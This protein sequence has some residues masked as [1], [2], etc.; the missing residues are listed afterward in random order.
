MTY[1]ILKLMIKIKFANLI[2]IIL[3]KEVIPELLQYQ[4]NSQNICKEL[5]R[6][7]A[8]KKLS[9]KQIDESHLA[10]EMMGLNSNISATNKACNAIFD[11]LKT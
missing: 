1:V 8:D 4:C 2:N 6:F 10:L 9:I 5:K 3:N 7:I 11:L